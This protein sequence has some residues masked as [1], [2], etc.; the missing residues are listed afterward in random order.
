MFESCDDL[1]GQ[2]SENCLITK[3]RTPTMALIC[4]LH[5]PH[6]KELDPDHEIQESSLKNGQYC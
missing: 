4:P 3:L 2:Q 6:G 5:Q 1:A